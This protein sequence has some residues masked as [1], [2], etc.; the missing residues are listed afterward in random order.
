MET[1]PHRTSQRTLRFFQIEVRDDRILAVLH[2]SS[3]WKRY[4]RM[5]GRKLFGTAELINSLDAK[6]VP[7]AGLSWPAAG[8]LLSPI[9]FVS[10]RGPCCRG[11][12]RRG[13]RRPQTASCREWHRSRRP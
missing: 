13:P 9:G 11:P 12:V 3:I 7:A 6:W 1:P 8:L 10:I 4:A 2:D 5:I